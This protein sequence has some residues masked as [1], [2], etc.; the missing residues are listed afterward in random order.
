MNYPH[1]YGTTVKKAVW[2]AFG[3]QTAFLLTIL[4]KLRKIGNQ[5][6]DVFVACAGVLVGTI[7][8]VG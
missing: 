5:G 7:G 8:A 4:I 3:R 6:V 2:Q 1:R